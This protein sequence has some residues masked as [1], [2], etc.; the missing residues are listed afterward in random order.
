[1]QS[2]GTRSRFDDRDTEAEPSK[3]GVLGLLCAAAGIDRDDWESLKPLT[4]MRFGVR[5]DNA[6]VFRSDYQT[7]QIYAPKV[8][9]LDL[10]TGKEAKGGTGVTR[11]HY[12]AD[13]SYVVGFQSEDRPLLEQLHVSLRNP[14][15][16]L[17]LG[18]K[19]FPPADPVY[20]PNGLVA[21][22]LES[23]LSDLDAAPILEEDLSRLNRAG[24]FD[25]RLPAVVDSTTSKGSLRND[26]PVA[27]F[28][29]RKYGSRWVQKLY[30]KVGSAS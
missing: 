28:S 4:Q 1:M 16:P 8:D 29:T 3:S 18:R 24:D 19:S 23:A 27:A 17:C 9:R 5:V 30:L 20:L 11:K 25:G 14:V 22:N 12:L 2:W 21:K 6:G 15:Y 26:V 13:A 7:A 10:L